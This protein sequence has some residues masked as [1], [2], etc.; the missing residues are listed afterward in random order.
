METPTVKDVTVFKQQ[1]E[2]FVTE[3]REARDESERDQDYDDHHQWTDEERSKLEARGQAAVVINRVKPKVNL[4]CGI[5]KATRTVPKCLPRTPKHEAGADAATEALR[6]ISD[7][8]DFPIISSAVFREQMVPG[9]GGA[10]IECAGKGKPIT[11]TKIPWDRYYY[12][13]HSREKDFS[14]KNY[15]GIVLWMDDAD[16][17]VDWP[18]KE[19]EIKDLVTYDPGD[20]TFDDKP[21]NVAWVSPDR[22]RIR[23]C[24]HFYRKGN[25]WWMCYFS[26]D[27]FLQ[28]PAPSPYK[29]EEGNPCNPIEMQTAYID[30]DLQRYGEVRAYIFLQ[31]EINHRRSR[32]LYGMSV[33]QTVGEDGAVDDI[34]E[35]KSEL[36]KANGHVKKNRGF[37]LEIL[38][39]SKTNEVDLLL[40]RESKSEI[41]NISA[42]SELAGKGNSRSGRQ[43]Q[44]QQQA[45][46]TELA[47]LYDGHKYWEKRVY[48]Q[49]WNRVKQFWGE[50]KWIR[51]TDDPSNLEW[52]GLNKPVT[53]GDLLLEAA[54]AEANAGG[55]GQATQELQQRTEQNDPWLEVKVTTE[56]SVVE[57][58]VD[59][60]IAESP[61]IHTL[62]QESFEVMAQLAE[63]YGP[64]EVPFAVMLE[65]MDMPN[66][67]AAKKLLEKA[68]T[69]DPQQVEAQQ[70]AQQLDLADKEATVK[71]KQASALKDISEARAQDLETAVVESGF[72]NVVADRDADTRGKQLDNLQ[73]EIETIKVAEEPVDNVSIS[74]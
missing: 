57:L 27:S 37:E 59:I 11:T 42:N 56:N 19:E 6:Y 18:D 2:A 26:G 49:W 65:M 66:K 68:K 12:D 61:D 72:E 58:D 52:V 10:I 21:L 3:T 46:M 36:A 67:D 55:P 48:R 8:N 31:D 28:D 23:V 63:R 62:K 5:Q 24:Q 70:A 30:R 43:S 35:M 47:S 16:A 4:L 1:F 38:D 14:D 64:E 45:G 17:I 54:K 33:R 60:I 9:Y 20:E 71:G 32:L 73:K 15:D 34:D 53:N 22:K 74:I 39:S 29:D 13:H 40:Y 50:E 41:D 69:P 25:V 51:V 7:N 44:V